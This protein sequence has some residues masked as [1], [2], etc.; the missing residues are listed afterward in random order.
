MTQ[1]LVSIRWEDV[2]RC[3]YVDHGHGACA[4]DA[5][6]AATLLLAASEGA[7]VIC[8][9]EQD[10]GPFDLIAAQLADHVR[11]LTAAYRQ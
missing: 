8:R 4:L 10:I 9:A 2:G 3:R 7:G 6:S 1:H 11:A 5:G